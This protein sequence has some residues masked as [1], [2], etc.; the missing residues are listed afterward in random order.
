VQ[1]MEQ[2]S[3]GFKISEADLE[4]RGPG[5]FLGRRQSGLPGFKLA[6]LIRDIK[7]LSEAREAAFSLLEK[8]PKLIKAEH[9]AMKLELTRTGG[10]LSTVG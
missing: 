5:E 2:T 8:D 9:Q 7:I 1:I 4:I 3:D 6:N 10:S